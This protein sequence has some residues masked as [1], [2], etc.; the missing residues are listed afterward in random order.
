MKRRND[1]STF[2]FNG[3]IATILLQF[4][5]MFMPPVLNFC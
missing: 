4:C 3:A 2:K 1:Q 5:H